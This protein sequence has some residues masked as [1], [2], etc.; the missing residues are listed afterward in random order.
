MEA[1]A[2]SKDTKI[3]HLNKMY[4]RR[5]KCSSLCT[6]QKLKQAGKNAKAASSLALNV[7]WSISGWEAWE[8]H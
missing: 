7:W 5:R 8:N 2:K 1:G 3:W 6:S 4:L